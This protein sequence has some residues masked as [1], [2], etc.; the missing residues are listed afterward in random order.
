MVGTSLPVEPLYRAC[1]GLLF[2]LWEGCTGRFTNPVVAQLAEREGLYL[3][4]YNGKFTVD[5][6]LLFLYG[7]IALLSYV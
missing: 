1:I 4:K 3:H 7:S 5:P 6:K 2:I